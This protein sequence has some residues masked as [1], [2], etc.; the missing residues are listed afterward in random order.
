MSA[1]FTESVK[2]K[3]KRIGGGLFENAEAEE[4]CVSKSGILGLIFFLNIILIVIQLC[5]GHLVLNRN[6]PKERTLE[7]IVPLK[8]K[9]I[10]Q[11]PPWNLRN[12]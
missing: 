4:A 12:F 3:I 7:R 2:A 11:T 8:Y 10:N 1:T 5:F 9:S 6:G